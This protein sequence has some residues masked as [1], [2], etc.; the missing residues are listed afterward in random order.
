MWSWQQLS[1]RNYRY[2]GEA[3]FSFQV[4]A[5]RNAFQQVAADSL[6]GVPKQFGLHS[7]RAGAARDA[8]EMG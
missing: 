2:V 6:G 8:E 3:M 4:D 7:L 1:L 5:V